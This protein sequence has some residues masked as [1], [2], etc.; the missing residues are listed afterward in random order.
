[1]QGLG[2]LHQA[3]GR[4]DLALSD[5]GQALELAT[6]LAQLADQARAHDGLAHAHRAGGREDL[7][8]Q[9]W[10]LALDILTGLGTEHTDESQ[11]SV[12]NIRASLT[13][14]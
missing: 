12:D 10:Q 8:R 13:S 1:M 2:R 7:A 11:A 6:N 3:T 14:G 9:H 4:P 5:H